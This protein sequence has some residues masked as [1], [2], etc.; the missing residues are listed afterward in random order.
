MVK[1]EAAHHDY[2]QNYAGMGTV[3]LLIY[4]KYAIP[5]KSN[6]V[7]FSYSYWR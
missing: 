4:D 1:R 2:S 5:V 7:R 6:Q 3:N